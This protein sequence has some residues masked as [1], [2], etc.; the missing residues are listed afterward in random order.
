M[1]KNRLYIHAN[2]E[3]WINIASSTFG[4]F[5]YGQGRFATLTLR[6]KDFSWD[7]ELRYES[8]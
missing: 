6:R 7:K 4:S 1:K 5:I 2:Y 3:L 8:K